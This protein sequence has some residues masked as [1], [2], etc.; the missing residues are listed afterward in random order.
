MVKQ[1]CNEESSSSSAK[2]SNSFRVKI[3]A[4][5]FSSRNDVV[6]EEIVYPPDEAHDNENKVMLKTRRDLVLGFAAA[7]TIMTTTPLGPYAAAA[8]QGE[9]SIPISASWT[10]VDLSNAQLGK[11]SLSAYEAALKNDSSRVPL[12]R[13]AITQRLDAIMPGGAKSGVV[14]DIGT[15][16]FAQL[17]ILAAE[18]GAGKVYAI[19]ANPLAA[20]L[21]RESVKKSGF[22]N[23]ITLLEGFS[24]DIS[25]PEQVDFVLA[26]IVGNGEC[27]SIMVEHILNV[28]NQSISHGLISTSYDR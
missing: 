19:E 12:F 16:P 17:A 14:L 3:L 21:A 24:A 1:Y 11:V 4:P 8:A 25:L 2:T 9:S 26:E 5:F 7:T 6:G 18:A 10:G 27:S 23:V 28:V 22:S 20:K 13:K 15:G